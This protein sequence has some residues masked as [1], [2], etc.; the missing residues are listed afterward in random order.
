M[1]TPST[2]GLARARFT[3]AFLVGASLLVIVPMSLAGCRQK[4]EEA[5]ST[6]GTTYYSGP[7]T[8]KPG[9]AAEKEMQSPS[10]KQGQPAPGKRPSPGGG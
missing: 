2:R 10:S 7:M 5:A 1:K 8:P 3:R 6:T 4:P 9:S